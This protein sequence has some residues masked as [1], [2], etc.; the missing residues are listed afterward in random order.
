LELGRVL[1]ICDE[2]CAI[3]G[4]LLTMITFMVNDER[5]EYKGNEEL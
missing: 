4:C 3:W 2:G 5:M 1:V